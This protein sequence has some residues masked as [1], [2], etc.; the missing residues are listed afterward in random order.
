[1]GYPTKQGER[2]GVT[3][4]A[5]TASTGVPGWKRKSM[6]RPVS[7]HKEWLKEGLIKAYKTAR[8]GK[9]KK[10]EATTGSGF[11]NSLIRPQ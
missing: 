1:M 5:P 9:N 10:P 2:K 7:D 8:L 3:T 6:E 4:T 11:A